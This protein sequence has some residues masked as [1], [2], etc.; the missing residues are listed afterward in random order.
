M[1]IFVDVLG[2]YD[3]AKYYSISFEA[4]VAFDNVASV[5]IRGITSPNVRSLC[6]WLQCLLNSGAIIYH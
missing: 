4:L 3:G 1:Q 2:K 5:Y 6:M